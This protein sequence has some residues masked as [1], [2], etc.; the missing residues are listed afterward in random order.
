MQFKLCNF[1]T[2]ILHSVSNVCLY[3]YIIS[4]VI[5]RSMSNKQFLKTNICSVSLKNVPSLLRMLQ[6]AF[7]I[8][9]HAASCFLVISW[10]FL[11]YFTIYFV[12]LLFSFDKV[13][14]FHNRILT[15]QKYE[16]VI[17]NCYS[18]CMLALHKNL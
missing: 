1:Y 13:S 7:Y 14:N 12:F 18:D 16:L 2:H 8:T 15:N 6:C 11:L 9:G 4:F 17:R 3:M 10:H 5:D